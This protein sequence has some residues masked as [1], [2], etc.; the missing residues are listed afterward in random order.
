[1]S[2]QPDLVPGLF[3]AADI[4]DALANVAVP[5]SRTE[6]LRQ[7][8]QLLRSDAEA[9]REFRAKKIPPA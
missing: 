3:A 5:N 7:F 6:T 8:A 2:D 4:A 1:M 9:L